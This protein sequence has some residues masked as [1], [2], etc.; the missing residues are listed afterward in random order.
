MKTNPKSAA[1]VEPF[2][3]DGTTDEFMSGLRRA[4]NRW[5]FN[6]A[7]KPGEPRIASWDLADE[8]GKL[9]ISSEPG[10]G[11]D[12]TTTPPKNSMR[13][14]LQLNEASPLG[15]SSSDTSVESPSPRNVDTLNLTA[16]SRESSIDT[17][18]SETSS[19]SNAQLSSLKNVSFPGDLT[20]DRPRSFSGAISN[21]E[22][23]RLQSIDTPSQLPDSLQDRGSPLTRDVSGSDNK[24]PSSV[25]SGE[26]IGGSAQP[27]Y[28]SI[29]A[30]PNQQQ[31]QHQPPVS[32]PSLSSRHFLQVDQL[33][34]VY[35]NG[36]GVPYAPGGA[37]NQY[38][39]PA[40]PTVHQR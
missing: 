15:T 38:N 5:S 20:K 27:M 39:E 9:G 12:G 14:V 4:G 2:V 1:P 8:I 17:L 28:P 24:P 18:N 30:Y 13:D 37:T 26:N 23:R 31:L 29:T 7:E 35:G 16:H 25:P 34:L 22:L 33:F 19:R 6:G 36:T 10:D 32:Y 11:T 40:P 21:A 3:R